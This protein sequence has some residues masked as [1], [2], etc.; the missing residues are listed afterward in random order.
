VLRYENRKMRCVET[1]P[2]VGERGIKENDAGGELKYD[3]F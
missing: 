3:I 1:V 2:G